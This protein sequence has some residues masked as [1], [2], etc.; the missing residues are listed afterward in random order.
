MST[1]G[2]ERGGPESAL[3]VEETGRSTLANS[4]CPVRQR[5]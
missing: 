1:G 3:P 2:K 4:H 5:V